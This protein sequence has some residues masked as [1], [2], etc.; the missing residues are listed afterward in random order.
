[1]DDT[2]VEPSAPFSPAP[3]HPPPTAPSAP[4]PHV[5]FGFPCLLGGYP[6][7]R[8]DAPSIH[9]VVVPWMEKHGDAVEK[10]ARPRSD[11]CT[12]SRSVAW[13]ANRRHKEPTRYPCSPRL[14]C[15]QSRG[16]RRYACLVIV[17]FIRRKEI[18]KNEVAC[19][20]VLYDS[21][22]LSLSLCLSLSLS[23]SLSGKR[24]P[25]FLSPFC[26]PRGDQ[27]NVARFDDNNDDDDDGAVDDNITRASSVKN[28]Q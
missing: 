2:A 4:S 25:R 19:S 5:L 17:L 8:R 21:V 13:R 9:M 26:R 7:K 24:I 23:L 3:L 11:L 15:T 16:H 18:R 20:K 28:G 22:S 27:F 10:T 14:S 1:M 6:G 12:Y